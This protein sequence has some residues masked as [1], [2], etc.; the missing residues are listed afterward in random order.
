MVVNT[1]SNGGMAEGDKHTF[2]RSLSFWLKV[3]STNIHC[4][5]LLQTHCKAQIHGKII[6]STALQKYYIEMEARRST[7]GHGKVLVY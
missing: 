7:N 1:N 5:L 3:K 6:Y 2:T 4:K